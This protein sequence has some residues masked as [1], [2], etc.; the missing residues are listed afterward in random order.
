[1]KTVTELLNQEGFLKTLFDSIPCGIFVIDRD[2][3][4][5][6][7]NNLL[8]RTF[9]VSKVDAI[10]RREGEA[11]RCIHAYKNQEGCGFAEYCQSCRVLETALDALS[12]K[13]IHRSKAKFQM[14]VDGQVQELILLVSAAPVTYE[15]ESLAIIIIE[16]ISEL[17]HLRRRLKRKQ[18]FA[19][20]VGQDPRMLELFDTIRDVA[21]VNVPVLIQ[22]ESG[23]GKELVAAAIH[24]EGPRANKPFVPVNCGALPEGLLESELF[25]HVRGAFTGAVRDK[26]GRFELANNGTL[27]LDEVADLSKVMQAKLLRVLQEGQFER[28]G[29]EKTISVDARII[30]A[31]NMDLKDQMK[32][33][34]FR[35]DLY[36]RIKVVPIYMPPLR[37]RK[38][39][40]PR[41]I[42]HFL[43][44]AVEEGQKA[45][46]ISKEALAIM[47]GYPWP[48]NIRELQSA[49][50]FALIKSKGE[51]VQPKDLP[52]E[53][54]KDLPLDLQEWK[55]KKSSPGPPRK[56]DPESVQTALA[57]SGGNKAKAAKFLSVGRATL[58]R[59]LADFPSVS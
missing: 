42:E 39:D 18:S 37:D 44:K 53:L 58:Y 38:N 49:V 14:V 8:E 46:D 25:G 27:F 47:M 10:N 13:R 28:V 9:G 20:I 7:V 17:N 31:T 19:G 22:G 6:A 59:F 54:R 3:R 23:T 5:Q 4:I 12:G 55:Y 48:G 1:M 29:G 36:Y 51:L 33:G 43:D 50:R 32:K 11:L 41:L 2:R 16:D 26:K 56:L 24:N 40:I 35:K 57:Q 15:G 34:H 30:S 21:D 52:L 45:T